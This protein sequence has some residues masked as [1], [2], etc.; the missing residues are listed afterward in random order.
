LGDDPEML[1]SQ[2]TKKGLKISSKLKAQRGKK[3][4]TESSKIIPSK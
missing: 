1:T 4:K 3:L 2:M